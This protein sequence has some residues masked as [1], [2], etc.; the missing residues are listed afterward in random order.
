MSVYKRGDVYW[1]KF[2]VRGQAP[3]R[4]SA[5]TSNKELARRIE[6]ERRTDVEQ[7]AAGIIRPQ[8]VPIF[9]VAAA[10]WMRFKKNEREA[11]SSQFHVHNLRLH[12]GPALNKMLLSTI[13][14]T[15]IKNYQLARREKG[16]AKKTVNLELETI[17]GVL[18]HFDQWDR[19]KKRVKMLKI[20]KDE[21][22]G[23]E[24]SPDEQI[25]ILDACAMSRSRLIYFMVA[26]ALETGA[27][28]GTIKRLK[29]ENL[30][31]VDRAIQF[32]KD[33]TPAGSGRV[34]PLNAKAF[35]AME[36]WAT[37]FPDRMSR[38]Y[39]FPSEQYA[40]SGHKFGAEQDGIM[41]RVIHD[42]NPLKHIGDIKTAWGSVKA[43]AGWILAGRP[44]S[45]E[46]IEPVV[47]RFHDLRHTAASRMVKGGA[48][49][50]TVGRILG[51]SASTQVKMALHYSHFLVD[52]LRG[53]MELAS[54][55][56][57][58]IVPETVPTSSVKGRKSRSRLV[59]AEMIET[60]I[61]TE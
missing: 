27:R 60:P 35:A 42:S 23:R 48:P 21:E 44:E 3:V 12:V 1:Y 52:D 53:A 40:A 30:N 45:R 6:R 58:K 56:A 11:S 51:W 19:I 4:E 36:W 20:G 15:M 49:I 14:E 7:D 28:Y 9:E 22:I 10:E 37:E 32:E 46:G 16:A 26:L 59:E 50:T 43:V 24:L 38:H 25:A 54:A 31:F 41:G 61:N 2:K 47:C 13:S 55:P 29:W 17:R 57:P 18:I 34:V 5:N 33:K 8:E 39:V